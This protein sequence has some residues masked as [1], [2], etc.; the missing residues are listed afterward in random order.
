MSHPVDE[1]R[2]TR[3]KSFVD[4]ISLQVDILSNSLPDK[5]SIT[6]ASY[7]PVLLAGSVSASTGLMDICLSAVPAGGGDHV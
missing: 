1:D 5:V 2:L 7:R 4:T 3:R 6:M